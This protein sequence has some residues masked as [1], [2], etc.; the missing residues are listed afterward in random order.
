MLLGFSPVQSGGRSLANR[1]G[2]SSRLPGERL[3]F[4]FTNK[5]KIEEMLFRDEFKYAFQNESV[6]VLNRYLSG[7]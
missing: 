3:S 5:P 2:G 7:S 1:V 4:L 6:Y